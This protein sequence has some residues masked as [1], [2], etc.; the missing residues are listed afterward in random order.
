MS[1]D[2][3]QS[4]EHYIIEIYQDRKG[5]LESRL[6]CIGAS[7]ASSVLDLNPYTSKEQFIQGK[8]EK[9]INLSQKGSMKYGQENEALIRELFKI[10]YRTKYKVEYEENVNVFNIKYPFLSCSPD[11]LLLEIGRKMKGRKGIL[12]IKTAYIKNQEELRQWDYGVPNYYYIQVLHQLLV[13]SDIDFV[14]L[15]VKLKIYDRK[16][17]E[18]SYLIKDYFI[19]RNDKQADIDYLLRQEVHFILEQRSIGFKGNTDEFAIHLCKTLESV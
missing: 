4:N 11:S 19:E 15:R 1:N 6:D 3:Y 13:M 5:W 9:K 17:K 18:S 2:L 8:L 12:E 14:V 16:T 10:D 7:D